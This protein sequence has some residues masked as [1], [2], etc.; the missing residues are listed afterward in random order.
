M[1]SC[2]YLKFL[3]YYSTRHHSKVLKTLVYV[4]HLICWT[5]DP[6]TTQRPSK[7]DIYPVYTIK[8][9]SGK[10]QATITQMYSKY[11]C[12]MCPLIA[13]CLLHRVNGVL[14]HSQE[15]RSTSMPCHGIHEYTRDHQETASMER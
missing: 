13:R 7:H 9:T 12:T 10:R 5:T 1:L 6:T 15:L 14:V 2:V 3:V 8:Q 4:G 11:T